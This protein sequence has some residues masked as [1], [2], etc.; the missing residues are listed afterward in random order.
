MVNAIGE[1]KYWDSTA[2]IIVWDDWGGFYDNE[3]SIPPL[4]FAGP[5]ERVPAIIVS[6]YARAGYVSTTTYQFG[7]V[8]H[9]IEDNWDLG[10]LGTTD[11]AT[12]IID[13][14]N[15]SQSPIPFQPISSSLDRSY[16]VREPHSYRPP[17]NDW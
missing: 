4:S 15:Y 9:Y 14:F 3:G 17:D 7:S 2:I 12:S 6:P 11:N 10:S 5:G 8:L 13:C 16:F 1:S